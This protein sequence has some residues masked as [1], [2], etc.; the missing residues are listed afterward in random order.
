MHI[1]FNHFHIV[2]ICSN[3]TGLRKIKSS[4]MQRFTVG[5]KY[6]QK[7]YTNL[8]EPLWLEISTHINPKESTDLQG[9]MW[10][11]LYAHMNPIRLFNDMKSRSLNLIWVIKYVDFGIYRLLVRTRGY[12]GGVS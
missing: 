11:E 7:A 2:T 12:S 9:P 3:K 10:L 1:M 6:I 5:S 4:T 8:Q